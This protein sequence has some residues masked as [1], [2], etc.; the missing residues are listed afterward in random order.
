M[1]APRCLSFRRAL[2]RVLAVAVRVTRRLVVP[3][4]LGLAVL[5]LMVFVREGR[6][7]PVPPIALNVRV[8]VLRVRVVR[9]TAVA[10]RPWLRKPVAGP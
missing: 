7:P 2:L 3:A 9:E 4:P 6:L 1:P 5:V 10:I 8:V